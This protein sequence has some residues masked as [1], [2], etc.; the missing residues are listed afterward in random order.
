[1][2]SI[3]LKMAIFG[4]TP[5]HVIFCHISDIPLPKMMSYNF[6]E[7]PQILLKINESRLVNKIL[8]T[9]Q[10]LHLKK[11]FNILYRNRNIDY[12]TDF[13]SL[14]NQLSIILCNKKYR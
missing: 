10:K 14:S 9:F 3:I 13:S 6:Y 12:T 8:F 7:P 11:M 4:P 5:L 1:M 2:T